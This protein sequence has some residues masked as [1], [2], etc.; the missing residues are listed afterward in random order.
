MSYVISAFLLLVSFI[1]S[2]SKKIYNIFFIF[3]FLMFAFSYMT[4]DW[5]IYLNR[6]YNYSSVALRSE[7]IFYFLN[8]VVNNFGF[9]FRTFLIF[10]SF[11]VCSTY[12]LILK[13]YDKSS[14]ILSL[15]FIYPFIME[16]SQIRFACAAPLVILALLIN[17]KENFSKKDRWLSVSLIIIAGLIHY[18]SLLALL[19]LLFREKSKQQTVIIVT[20]L[21]FS[22]LFFN[23]AISKITFLSGNSTLV[24]KINFVISLNT[25]KKISKLLLSTFRFLLFFGGYLFIYTIFLVTK[26]YDSS[27]QKIVDQVFKYNIIALLFIPLI[28][29][30]TDVYR[31]QQLLSILNYISYSFFLN[32]KNLIHYPKKIYIKDFVFVFVC[33]LF[34]FL[35]LYFLVLNNNNFN[36]VFKSFFE[37]NLIFGR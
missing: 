27:K 7:P 24:N 32:K 6:F 12:Y 31:L 36:T 13:K 34:A 5:G 21:L 26:K 19:Y 30:S 2:N 23:L 1:N 14:F 16:V 20:I 10:I 9:D 37:N 15:Y 25:N 11:F 22:M 29:Y 33:I 8:R 18:A 28:N 35:N 3:M 17:A 4:A